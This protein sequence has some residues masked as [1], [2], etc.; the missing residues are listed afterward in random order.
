[1]QVL[2]KN[3]ANVNYKDIHGCTPLILAASSPKLYIVDLVSASDRRKRKKARAGAVQKQRALDA[4]KAGKKRGD[5]S[6]P[7][8]M[9]KFFPNRIELITMNILLKESSLKVDDYDLMKR[10]ALTY[11]ARYGRNYAISRLL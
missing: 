3:S 2:L 1:M 5:I 7:F 10:T 9:W 6:D 4:G 8:T 11:A